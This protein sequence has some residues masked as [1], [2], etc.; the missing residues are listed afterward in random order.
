METLLESLVKREANYRRI[1]FAIR[2]SCWKQRPNCCVRGT[3]SSN[4]N[5]RMTKMST[6]PMENECQACESCLI[7]KLSKNQ[8]FLVFEVRER[9]P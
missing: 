9:N 5:I 2:G 6:V 8:S 7:Y 4:S 3:K 1:L